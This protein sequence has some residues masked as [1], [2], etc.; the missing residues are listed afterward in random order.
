MKLCFGDSENEHLEDLSFGKNGFK[1]IIGR[2]SR[3]FFEGC[4]ENVIDALLR[5]DARREILVHAMNIEKTDVTKK[6]KEYDAT[7][8]EGTALTLSKTIVAHGK[9]LLY[10]STTFSK[11]FAYVQQ[12]RIFEITANEGNL[13]FLMLVILTI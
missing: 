2:D 13:F 1:R 7:L 3:D 6:I 12:H 9:S 10:Q 11:Y 5:H 4:E 8:Y